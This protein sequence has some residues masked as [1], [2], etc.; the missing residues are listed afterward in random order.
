MGTRDAG[1]IFPNASAI[2]TRAGESLCRV[3]KFAGCVQS[4]SAAKTTGP[5]APCNGLE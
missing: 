4:R 3:Q 2:D 5:P 1:G